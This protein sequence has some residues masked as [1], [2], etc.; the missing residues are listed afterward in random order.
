MIPRLA[1]DDA[2]RLMGYAGAVTNADYLA[3]QALL[4]DAI[5]M[6]TGSV[7]AADAFNGGFRYTSTG[8]LRIYD[9][10]SALPSPVTEH[11]GFSMTENGQV[12]ITTDAI[13]SDVARLNGV[14]VDSSGR[15]YTTLLDPVAWFRF[16]SGITGVTT[17]SQWDDVTGNANHLKQ[18]TETNQPALQVDGSILF[19][20]VDNYLKCD[21]FT[22]NQPFTE[23]MLFRQITWTANDYFSDGNTL[24]STGF[25][26][27][28]LGATPEVSMYAG[29]GV[30]TNDNLLLGT[31]GIASVVF[32]GA[33][34][35][36]QINNTI[37]T[38]G[39]VGINNAGGFTL[40]AT[41]NGSTTVSNIQVKEV[42]LFPV[43]HD[44][45]TRLHVAR[46]LAHN[47]L[48]F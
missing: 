34:S 13:G 48:V 27:A 21:A 8:A 45:N 17:V 29:T 23:Y 43:A 18:A 11:R 24:A 39:N 3:S 22:L 40:G 42:I 32:N 46:Y 33:S 16:N 4:M 44:A 47:G 30:A 6:S 10:T 38:T 36:I 20:G 35:L 31:Y 2:G 37:A 14:A 25:L 9:A 41:G 1:L 28:E 5:C 19:D 15:I 7:A 26:Q 12:C